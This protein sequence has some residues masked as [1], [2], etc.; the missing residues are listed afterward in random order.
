MDGLPT[1]GADIVLVRGTAVPT[2]GRPSLGLLAGGNADA[3]GRLVAVPRLALLLGVVDVLRVA[4]AE[5]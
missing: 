5:V 1:S 3:L 4:L 2:D